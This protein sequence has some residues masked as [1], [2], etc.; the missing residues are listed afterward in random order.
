MSTRKFN[1]PLGE[2]MK[3][4]F[5]TANGE[6]ADIAS[7]VNAL[8]NSLAAGGLLGATGDEMYDTLSA[9]LVSKINLLS[10]KMNEMRNDVQSARE[11]YEEAERRARE[12]FMY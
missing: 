10:D 2:A 12:R 5:G 6:L 8:A 9:T 1:K 7:E 3:G 11:Q 4:A